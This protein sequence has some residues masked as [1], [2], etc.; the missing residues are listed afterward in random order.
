[1]KTNAIIRI[2]LYSLIILVLLGILFAG[3][4]FTLYTTDIRTESHT[5][6]VEGPLASDGATVTGAVDADLVR[7]IQINWVAGNITIRS[8]ENATDINFTETGNDQERYR[9]V[10]ALREDKLEINYCEDAITFPSFGFNVE[11][12]KELTITVPADWTCQELELDVAAA[13]VEVHDLTIQEVDFDGASGTCAFFLCHVKDLNLDTA[14]GNIQFS[15]Q[16]ETLD[17]DAASA[18]FIGV[19]TNVPRHM[20]MDSASGTLDLTLPAE[21]GFTATVEGLSCDFSSQFP[22]SK[23]GNS[24]LCGDGGCQIQVEG[25]NCDVIIRIA[26]A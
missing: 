6:N 16:L 25:M 21:A 3:L 7:R 13:N 26:G 2:I 8:D 10:Y 11:V 22:T 23:I 1:M 18:S 4:G 5:T 14:S 9:M 12:S 17:F 24:Y 19:L 15:G 20:E